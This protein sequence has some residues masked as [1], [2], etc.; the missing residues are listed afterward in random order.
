MG[1]K[2]PA[3]IQLT[4][5]CYQSFLKIHQK[6]SA[7]VQPQRMDWPDVDGVSVPETCICTNRE[8]L[9]EFAYQPPGMKHVI[10]L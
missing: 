2:V 1:I 4:R 3:Y 5:D 9:H 7:Q 6:I 8:V 10:W